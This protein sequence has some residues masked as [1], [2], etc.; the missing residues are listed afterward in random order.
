MSVAQ[1][2]RTARKDRGLKQDELGVPYSTSMVGM[3]E[4]GQRQVAPDVMPILSERLDHP[5]VDMECAR[6]ATGGCGPA[7]MDGPAVDLHRAAMREKTLEELRE[8]MEFMART[9]TAKPPAL[10]TEAERR[11]L[12]EHLQQVIDGIQWARQFVGVMCLEYG[13]SHRKVWRDH[14]AKMRSKRYIVEA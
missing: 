11:K 13:I 5:A 1:A 9:N 3:I 10:L 4:R 8:A 7:W 14:R 6:Q 12:E 2:I